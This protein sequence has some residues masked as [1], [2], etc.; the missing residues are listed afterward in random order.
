MNLFFVVVAD[1]PVATT[2]CSCI[3]RVDR[4]DRLRFHEPMT[5]SKMSCAVPRVAT[6]PQHPFGS[7]FQFHLQAVQC[8]AISQLHTFITQR[9]GQ[10]PPVRHP[11]CM[12]STGIGR[13]ADVR[14]TR[15][16]QRHFGHL[17]QRA[18]VARWRRRAQLAPT[19]ATPLRRRNPVRP[20]RLRFAVQHT[21]SSQ[22]LRRSRLCV[23]VGCHHFALLRPRFAFAW[24]FAFAVAL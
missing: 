18:Y 23:T 14:S 11:G 17:G 15:R 16:L 9:S 22:V 12:H 5:T 21:L 2:Q 8:A 6:P 1:K 4:I 13:R 7:R 3:G 10:Q 19:T 24:R 20:L